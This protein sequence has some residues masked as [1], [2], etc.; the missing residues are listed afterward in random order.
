MEASTPGPLQR[1]PQQLLRGAPS[2]CRL[3]CWASASADTDC[4][5]SQSSWLACSISRYSSGMPA[6][7][8]RF[9]RRGDR[10]RMQ[11]REFATGQVQHFEVLEGMPASCQADTARL[12]PSASWVSTRLLRRGPGHA[13]AP[14]KPKLQPSPATH[15]RCSRLKQTRGWARRYTK[16][17][18]M[19]CM[20]LLRWSSKLRGGGEGMGQAGGCRVAGSE[21]GKHN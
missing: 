16:P 11:R 17:S 18:G 9:L 12:V 3:G 13:G 8:L 14:P 5:C 4:S 6:S 19:S 2:A 7:S 1:L 21:E 15:R 10:E 20:S